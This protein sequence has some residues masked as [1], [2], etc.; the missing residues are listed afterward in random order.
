M[1]KESLMWLAK[2]SVLWPVETG[3]EHIGLGN[4]YGTFDQRRDALLGYG[5]GLVGPNFYASQ[6]Q[7]LAIADPAKTQPLL[8][9]PDPHAKYRQEDRAAQRA[10]QELKKR[11]S[12]D[13]ANS[14]WREALFTL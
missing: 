9:G 6:Q 13:D 11:A 7:P 12:V 1:N 4:V 14:L 8:A 3:A 2:G 5:R 10:V